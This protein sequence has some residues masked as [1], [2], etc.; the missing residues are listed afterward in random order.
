MSCKSESGV[1]PNNSS[2]IAAFEYGL[3]CCIARGRHRHTFVA[4]GHPLESDK[5]F[6]RRNPY[7]HISLPYR[8][9]YFGT[10]H[11]SNLPKPAKTPRRQQIWPDRMTTAHNFAMQNTPSSSLA[12]ICSSCLLSGTVAQPPNR[13]AAVAPVLTMLRERSPDV[14]LTIRTLVLTSQVIEGLANGPCTSQKFPV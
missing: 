8:C 4:I 5:S 12:L 13:P 9:M 14:P 2:V 7:G 11:L 10:R 1:A 6:S 3:R